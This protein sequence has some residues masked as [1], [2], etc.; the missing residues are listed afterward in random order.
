MQILQHLTNHKNVVKLYDSFET[1]SHLCFVMELCAGG[2]LLSF[3]RRR[4]KLDE[5]LAKFLF[6]QVAK[7]LEYCHRN[8]VFHR[9][10]KLE[11]LLLDDEGTVKICDFGVS[12]L[13]NDTSDLI[14]D[15]CGTPAY[16]APEVF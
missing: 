5:T 14:K 12:Q 15:Q 2:D 8:K 16:M 9:D 7:G 10:I 3:V 11:N 4:K 1:K 13:L 6:K